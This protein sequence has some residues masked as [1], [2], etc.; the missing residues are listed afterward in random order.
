[1][2]PVRSHSVIQKI[3]C[4]KFKRNCISLK[5]HFKGCLK[6]ILVSPQIYTGGS[7]NSMLHFNSWTIK[8]TISYQ[9]SHLKMV[10]PIKA[11]ISVPSKNSPISRLKIIWGWE[12]IVMSDLWC[13]MCDLWSTTYPPTFSQHSLRSPQCRNLILILNEKPLLHAS[14]YFIVRPG[15]N[16][17][18]LDN[19]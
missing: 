6:P 7:A 8:N 5:E 14:I 10:M 17:F 15:Y 16:Q 19:F 3:S 1:M 13:M 11:I 2:L 18:A 9:T 4:S 12:P